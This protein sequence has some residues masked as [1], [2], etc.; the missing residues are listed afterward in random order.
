MFILW[1]NL[2]SYKLILICDLTT[3]KK[4]K[5]AKKLYLEINK[6]GVFIMTLN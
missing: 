6:F 2:K 1:E 3:L 5:L 4:G